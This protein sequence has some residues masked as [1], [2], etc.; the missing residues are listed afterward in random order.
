V[1]A[2]VTGM[3]AW[4]LWRRSGQMSMNKLTTPRIHHLERSAGKCDLCS[5]S[6]DLPSATENTI[7]KYFCSGLR[8]L[9]LSSVP[10]KLF[11]IPLVDPTWTTLKI[12][13]DWS[14][15]PTTK[16]DFGE[17]RATARLVIWT[18]FNVSS[19]LQMLL[20]RM[21]TDNLT[22]IHRS[23]KPVADR[24]KHNPTYLAWLNKNITHVQYGKLINFS[25]FATMG[26]NVIGTVS[27][28]C[29][30]AGSM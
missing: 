18:T 17:E 26:D 25:T 10:V 24:D 6:V 2:V 27:I 22:Y 16:T 11:P 1:V 15:D 8:S 23:G 20:S 12:M 21:V 13:I 29:G 5:V 28:V 9:T 14:T 19:S 4:K 7:R 3:V 30:A